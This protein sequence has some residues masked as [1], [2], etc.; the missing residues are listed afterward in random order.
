MSKTSNIF[1][2]S[3]GSSNLGVGGIFLDEIH[4]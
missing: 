1:D 2:N 4:I 3:S